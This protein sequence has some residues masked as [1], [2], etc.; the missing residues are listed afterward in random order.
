[1]TVR[2]KLY[3]G[4]ALLQVRLRNMHNT[5]A[6][7]QQRSHAVVS[8]ALQENQGTGSQEQPAQLA[9]QQPASSGAASAPAAPAAVGPYGNDEVE[10]WGHHYAVPLPQ[11]NKYSRT[12]QPRQQEAGNR[13]QGSESGGRLDDEAVDTVALRRAV[14]QK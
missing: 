2:S 14:N 1:M 8:Q 7:V 11:G 5:L 6:A 3:C 12:A 13:S 9:S 4:A 10:A